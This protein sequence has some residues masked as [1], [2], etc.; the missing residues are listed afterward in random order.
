[1]AYGSRNDFKAAGS[2]IRT[3]ARTFR[4]PNVSHSFI[5]ALIAFVVWCSA[6][7]VMMGKD[8]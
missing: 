6:M 3:F 1:V 4:L 7:N 5:S 8:C 2:Q